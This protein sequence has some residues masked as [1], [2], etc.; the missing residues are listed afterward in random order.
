MAA[1]RIWF[2]WFCWHNVCVL[3]CFTGLSKRRLLIH[4]RLVHLQDHMRTTGRTTDAIVGLQN[5]KQLCTSC[6]TLLWEAPMHLCH[7]Q[8]GVL[9][10]YKWA[11]SYL[12]LAS[13]TLEKCC[14]H[15]LIEVY[16]VP[17]RRVG[18][19]FPNNIVQCLIIAFFQ[20]KLR[21]TGPKRTC[22]L[23]K[24]FNHHLDMKHLSGGL[25]WQRRSV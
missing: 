6:Q 12:G 24:L 3:T 7:P 10:D 11:N 17:G 22:A 13:D 20:D 14:L 16:T 4:I 9:Q 21:V 1:M 8:R 18:K 2:F 15:R 23:I 25:P 5:K 19:H